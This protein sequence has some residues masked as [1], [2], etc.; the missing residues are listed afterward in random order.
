IDEWQR[1]VFGESAIVA[2]NA[3]HG[4]ART[5]RFQATFTKTADR[6]KSERSARDV[7]FADNAFADP[8]FLHGGGNSRDI[9]NFPDE[10]MA[11]NSM[12]A[13]I[14]AKN[15]HVGIAN[16]SETHSYQSPATAQL[17]HWGCNLLQRTVLHAERA[18]CFRE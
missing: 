2:E 9:N 12:E 8:R 5:M 4:A 11:G 6:L 16:P 13:V 14:A 1:E 10:F 17:R 15:F 18:H 3:E 7:D